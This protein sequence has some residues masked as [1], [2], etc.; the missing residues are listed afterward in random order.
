MNSPDISAV[1][2]T[3]QRYDCLGDAIDSLDRQN[4]SRE[5]YEIIV[6]D[7]SP[8]RD[9]SSSFAQRYA[10]HPNLSW[11]V[12]HTAGLSN[13]RNAALERARGK[14]IAYMDDDAL[15]DADWLDRLLSAFSMFGER[16][17]VVGGK[18]EPIWESPRPG[19]LHDDYLRH[20]SLVDLKGYVPRVLGTAESLAGTNIAFRTDRLN[21][22]GGFSTDLGRKG[23][24]HALLSNEENEICRILRRDGLSIVYAPDAIVSHRIGSARLTQEWFRRRVA[25]Q[26]VSDYLR[27]GARLFEESPTYW[28]DVLLFA[29]ALSPR[30]RTLRALHVPQTDPDMF[31][32]QMTALYNYTVALLTGFVEIP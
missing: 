9:F 5:S 17:A 19:W 16:A 15:A 4:L 13:A 8:D 23:G 11:I 21:E 27:D 20:L 1:I 6:V 32:L 18:V 3:Y 24:S 2:C 10:E 7:N 25:W 31:R 14:I 29:N 12:E 22:T 26:A 28:N 30:N